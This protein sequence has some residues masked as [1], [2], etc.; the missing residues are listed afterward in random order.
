MYGSLDMTDL[1]DVYKYIFQISNVGSSIV[2]EVKQQIK[3]FRLCQVTVL[4]KPVF[5]FR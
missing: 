3:C 4:H 2:W 1:S 5:D